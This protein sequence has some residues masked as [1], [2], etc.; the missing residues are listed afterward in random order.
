[1]ADSNSNELKDIDVTKQQLE[2][3]KQQLA[4][5]PQQTEEQ[6]DLPKEEP[7]EDIVTPTKEEDTYAVQSGFVFGLHKTAAFF[8]F[9]EADDMYKD[10]RALR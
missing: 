5:Q 10:S 4:E 6:P 2:A 1:M 8:K 3:V 9:A 7:E